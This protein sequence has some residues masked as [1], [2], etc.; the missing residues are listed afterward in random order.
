MR[1]SLL[2]L[3]VTAPFLLH[4]SSAGTAAPAAEAATSP[5]PASRTSLAQIVAMTGEVVAVDP[6]TRIVTLRGPLGGEVTGKVDD[7]VKNLAQVKAGDMVTI[8]YYQSVALSA[9]KKGESTPLF[10]GA[11]ETAAAGERPAA[12]AATETRKT[13][14]VVSVDAA[15]RSVVFQGE[16]GTLF[17]VEVQRP[18]FVQKLQGLR[19][20]DQL[21]VVVTEA[22]ITGVT[23][24]A[25]GEKPALAYEAATLIIDRGEVVRRMNNVL[26]VR[27]ER[28]RIVRVAVDPAFKFKID[29]KEMTVTDLQPGTQ[30]TRTAFRVIE[31]ASYE[32]E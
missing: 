22:L 30:L 4:C 6:A 24:A 11:A 5:P 19:A 21:D 28:G 7:A 23:P 13:V 2:S 12:V 27:N 29:G 17:P 26:Y 15:K 3:L 8:A 14:T 25:A 20:G 16:D 9:A 31:S 10:A 18:E 32:A 1:R